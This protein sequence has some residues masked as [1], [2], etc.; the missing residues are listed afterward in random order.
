M[1][2]LRKAKLNRFEL[3]NVRTD[4]RQEREASKANPDRF[5]SMRKQMIRLHQEVIAEG[6]VWNFAAPQGL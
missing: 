3:F 5:L 6:P 2:W 1:K 4:I